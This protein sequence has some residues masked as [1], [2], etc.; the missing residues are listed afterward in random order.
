MERNKVI[1]HGILAYGLPEGIDDLARWVEACRCHYSM[2]GEHDVDGARELYVK[3]GGI[4]DMA[5]RAWGGVKGA[6]QY[7]AKSIL[8]YLT[9]LAVLESENFLQAVSSILAGQKVDPEVSKALVDRLKT[10]AV[11]DGVRY[12]GQMAGANPRDVDKVLRSTGGMP[13]MGALAVDELDSYYTGQE[14]PMYCSKCRNSDYTPT[15]KV[16]C[17]IQDDPTVREFLERYQKRDLIFKDEKCPGYELEVAIN[18]PDQDLDAGGAESVL[19]VHGVNRTNAAMMKE[20]PLEPIEQ[21]QDPLLN[22]KS[23]YEQIS[24]SDTGD[25][26]AL[27]E[28]AITDFL[29]HPSGVKGG[30]ALEIIRGVSNELKRK[31]R[32]AVGETKDYYRLDWM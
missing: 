1:A 7:A 6:F 22:E 27:L 16:G 2:T 28:N 18:T 11:T 13:H 10:M 9:T 29:G 15:G 30:A 12:I 4:G 5:G 26:L 8:P 20:V 14:L 21:G 31:N 23:L 32:A 25:S 3:R 24:R 19:K 17:T